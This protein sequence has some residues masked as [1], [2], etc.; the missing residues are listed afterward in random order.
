MRRLLFTYTILLLSF[1]CIAQTPKADSLRQ[2][3]VNEKDLSN[4]FKLNK[5]I[6]DELIEKGK[7]EQVPEYN[8][9]L[10]AIA[11]KLKSDSLLMVSYKAT[12]RYLGWKT[13]SKE[14]LEYNLKALAIAEKKY[15]S[16]I[17]AIYSGMGS[18]YNDLRNYDKALFYLRKALS[19]MDEKG[20]V[21]KVRGNMYYQIAYAFNYSGKPDS[22]LR[23]AQLADEIYM[24]YPTDKFQKFIW[25]LTANAYAELGN[26]KLAE[27]FY[28]NSIDDD[29]TSKNFGDATAAGEYSQFLLKQN[30]ISEARYYGLKGLNAALAAQARHRVHARRHR[31][32]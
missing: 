24:K 10:Y 12:A 11:A 7:L 5:Q 29:T 32:R 30:R 26:Y 13:D 22:T 1:G 4:Q 9:R 3:L 28:R 18:T 15:P 8:S 21:G 27:S 2:L 20:I 19:L 23:Y 31:P 17:P 25:P 6:A 14:E 16:I